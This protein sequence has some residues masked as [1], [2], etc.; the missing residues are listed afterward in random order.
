MVTLLQ[1]DSSPMGEASLSRQLTREYTRNWQRAHPDGRV[2]VRDLCRVDMPPID[3]EWIAANFTPQAERTEAQNERL[4]LSTTFT[5]ELR[6]ADEYVIG[7]PMHNWG[8]SARFK[9]WAD[10]IVRH[11]ETIKSTLSGTRGLLGERRATF[12]IAAGAVYGPDE[13]QAQLNFLTPWLRV[14]FRFL[15][16]EDLRFV[17]ADGAVGVFTRQ[18]DPAEFLAPHIRTV[19]RLFW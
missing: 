6:S 5:S 11:E 8:P 18:V 14:L 16:M 12:I 15:G 13:A 10:H 3:A 2:M 19:Q 1:I 4:A 17:I 9:L 7:M